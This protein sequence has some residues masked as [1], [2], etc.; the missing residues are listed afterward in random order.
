MCGIA[1][2][3]NLGQGVAPSRTELEQMI[4]AVHHR[5]PDGYG[6]YN[7]DRVGLAHAR[8]SIID[9]AGGDQPIHNEDK[10][11][12]VVFNG[13]IFNY[14]ELRAELEKQGHQFYTHS[15]TEV[16]VHLYE[17]HGEGFVEH[18]NGQF[19]IALWDE[20]NHTLILTRDRAG[21]RPLFYTQTGNRLYFA[22]EVKSLFSHPAIH[23]AIDL[24]AL[25]EVFTFWTTL[26]PN[27]LFESVKMLPPGHLMTVQQGEIKIQRY[28][29]W[30][31]PNE[32]IDSR[33]S[34]DDWAE[35]LKALMIDSVRLQLR[36]DVPVGAYL[37]GGLDSSVL[38][39]LIKNFTDTPLRT[40][41]IGFEDEEF[42]ESAYQQDL[43]N[44]LGTH[45]THVLC[46]RSDIGE[47]FPKVIR[48]TESSIVRT[49]PTPL[50][51]L[52]GA[53]REA[54]YKVVL[55]GEGAD[56]V[57]GGYDIFKE[58]KVRRFWSHAPESQWRPLIL[59][60][61]YPY[62]KHS[63]TASGA[64]TQ[65]FFQQGMEHLDKPYFAHIPRWAT[66][67][68]I[69]QFLSDEARAA[70]EPAVDFARIERIL[71][72][73]IQDWKPLNRDQYIEA[74]TLLSGYLLSSQGDRVGMA[75]SIEGRFPFL[76]HRVIEFA[77]RLPSR[78][79]IM[80]LNEKYMLKKT[81]QGLIPESI[82]NRSKQPYR[83]PDSQS[84]FQDG[85][86]L[87]YVEDLFSEAR[88]KKAGYFNPKATSMLLNKCARG[89][90]L[91]FG[92]NMAFVGILSTMLIDEQFITQPP[93]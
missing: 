77:A 23:R 9:L 62:L 58:A 12:Q 91:G 84:F 82:R 43:V 21:I 90:A 15:D 78:Y 69:L 57:F 71:P 37:S 33:K 52:S 50:M 1:G 17:E 85:K 14:V 42:D 29:D 27:S 54:G 74:N 30:Q 2:I 89:K 36:S 7:H 47:A 55:T 31:Y 19:A 18:L 5:G 40:F 59:Q 60:R 83:A 26:P 88:I 87:D 3:M 16:I 93:A 68:R 4:H 73:E 34:A 28:W 35:E 65:R 76:D 61:L 81:M 6:F 48:H 38:T 63:P 46:K 25:Q 22:S 8:L 10:T 49:A 32:A 70:V 56:E 80:G 11:L 86:P 53:V 45:H 41:S 92:D 13:E 64:F 66:T 72:A 67:Q 24:T 75:N 20:A 44:Y 51:L 39:S 79:K